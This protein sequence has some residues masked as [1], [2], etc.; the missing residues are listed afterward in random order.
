MTATT[1]PGGPVEQR[2]APMARRVLAQASFELRTTLRNGEQLL[3][4]LIL[5]VLIL[6]A[7]TRSDLVDVG[8]EDRVAVVA[9]GVLAL[10][11]MSTAFTSQAITTAFDRRAGVLRLLATTPLGRS[12]LVLGKALGVLALELVQLAVLG[13]VAALLGWRPSVSGAPLALVALLLGTLAFSGLALL[14]AGVLRA[15]AVLAVANLVWVLLLVGGAVILPADV[16][17]GPLAAAAPW[18]PSGALG[19]AL[20]SASTDGTVQ[21]LPLLVLSGWSVLLG[22]AVARFARWS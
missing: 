12:G 11:V 22:A 21:A 18:L 1:A 10:A 15:E 7:L 4:T 20:R 8:G 13:G 14:L 3:L 17:P 19:D 6:V 9:P 5:P 16:L 2:A